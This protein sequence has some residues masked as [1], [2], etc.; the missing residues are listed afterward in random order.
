MS[1]FIAVMD[2]EWDKKVLRVLLGLNRSRSEVD[3]LGIDSDAIVKDKNM[4]FE[5]I[6]SMSVVEEEA[7]KI[8]IETLNRKYER[9]NGEIKRHKRQLIEKSNFW[10]EYQLEEIKEKIDNLNKELFNIDLLKR[11]DKS[12]LDSFKQ[13]IRRIKNNIIQERRMKL[14]KQG[15]G[16]KTVMDENDEIFLAKAIEDKATAHGRR[17]DSVFY[18]NQ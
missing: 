6:N 7:E 4:V 11:K 16:R 15:S 1:S 12:K 17:K 10:K 9:M 14:R 8:L 5:Y 2:T 3:A 18:L 13:R